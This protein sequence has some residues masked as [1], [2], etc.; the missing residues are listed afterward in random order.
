MGNCDFAF[1]CLPSWHTRKDVAYMS[2]KTRRD[3]RS[4]SDSRRYV[5]VTL[6]LVP[7]TYVS[8]LA[9]VYQHAVPGSQGDE[10]R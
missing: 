5:K 6:R 7:M 8:S 3:P 9:V 1:R 4:P 10:P 2:R